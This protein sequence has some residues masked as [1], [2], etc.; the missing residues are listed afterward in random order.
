M[1]TNNHPTNRNL[2]L[3]YGERFMGLSVNQRHRPLVT[4]YLQAIHETLCAANQAHSQMLV[5]RIDL[6]LPEQYSKE[7]T[8]DNLLVTKFIQSIKS[9]ISNRR[10]RLLKVGKRCHETRLRYIW[11]RESTNNDRPHFHMALIL[12]RDT[13]RGLGEFALGNGSLYSMIH[14]AW[15]SALD[16]DLSSVTGLVHIPNNAIYAVKRGEAFEELF[17][18]LSYFAKAETKAW[19]N[20]T[21]AFGCSRS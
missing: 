7:L 15:A 6:N 18:R 14:E 5:I 10:I 12:N 4:N 8:R 3:F 21:H 17:Y 2:K 9:K 19:G 1:T 11:I 20:K 13:F 16:R